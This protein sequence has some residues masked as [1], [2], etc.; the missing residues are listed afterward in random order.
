MWNVDT[1]NHGNHVA[2]TIAAMRNNNQG[3]AGVAPGVSLYIVDEFDDV[4]CRWTY[5]SDVLNAAQRCAANNAKIINMSLG[6]RCNPNT[7]V[8]NTVVGNGFVDFEK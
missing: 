8:P 5:N 1:C 7:C 6:C 2:G 4:S 3:V